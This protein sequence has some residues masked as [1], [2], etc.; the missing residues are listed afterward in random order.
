MLDSQLL[1]DKTE[2][3]ASQLLKRGFKLDVAAFVSLEERRKS[4]Q[5]ATQSLQNERNLR[6]KAIGEAKA[7]GENIESMREEVARLAVELEQK[8]AELE[9]V[10]QQIEAMALV[11]PNIPHESVPV[12]N[13]ELDNQ[14]V[15]RWGEV[16]AFDFKVKRNS[17]LYFV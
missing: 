12:G 8:K 16:P 15:R 10:L 2:F 6:S 9:Q 13:S 1:R 11:M 3:V 5:V 17:Q 4:L 14:E 7:R